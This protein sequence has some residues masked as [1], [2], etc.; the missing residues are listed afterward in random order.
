MPL[1]APTLGKYFSEYL[2][3]I[4]KTVSQVLARTYHRD[5]QKF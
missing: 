3:K 4:L 5:Q 1:I 2:K